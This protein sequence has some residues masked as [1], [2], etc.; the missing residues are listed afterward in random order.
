MSHYFILV[1]IALL[2]ILGAFIALRSGSEDVLGPRDANAGGVR[3]IASNFSSMIL[4]V[5]GYLALLLALQ[6]FVRFPSFLI[7]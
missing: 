1:P 2:F 4:R 7:W 6:G 5:A 3:L